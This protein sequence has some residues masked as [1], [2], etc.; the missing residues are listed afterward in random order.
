VPGWFSELQGMA[1]PP[2]SGFDRAQL[3]PFS[4]GSMALV[5]VAF[6]RRCENEILLR[7]DDTRLCLHLMSLD[8]KT[9]QQ[10]VELT[11][12]NEPEQAAPTA[13]R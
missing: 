10:Y 5:Q 4:I 3:I 9:F 1:G 11:L 13:L 7:P 12:C 2:A 8:W 6:S